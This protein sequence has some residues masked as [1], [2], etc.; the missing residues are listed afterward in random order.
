MNLLTPALNDVDGR[1][2]QPLPAHESP[3]MNNTI[4]HKEN[5]PI[6]G[7]PKKKEQP[8]RET[9]ANRMCDCTRNYCVCNEVAA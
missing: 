2:R 8:N 7:S 3:L 6:G 9:S 5:P 1:S 4:L